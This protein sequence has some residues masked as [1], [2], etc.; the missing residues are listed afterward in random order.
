MTAGVPMG[1]L[2]V[3]TSVRCCSLGVGPLAMF[4]TLLEGRTAF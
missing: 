4:V 3:V 1:L 2:G